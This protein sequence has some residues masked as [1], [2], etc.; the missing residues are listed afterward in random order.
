IS[1]D[2][3]VA[4]KLHVEELAKDKAGQEQEKYDLEKALELQKQLDERQEVV[5]GKKLMILIGLILLF[6]RY[7][8]LQNRPFSIVEVRKNMYQNHAFVL[9]DSEIEKEVMK[10]PGFD[11]Q[12]KFIKKNEKIEASGFVQKQPAGEEKEK[13]KDAESSKQVKEEIAQQ[14]DVVAEQVMKESSK[15]AGRR[16]KRKVAKGIED[17]DKMKKMQDDPEKHTLME[18]VEI[19]LI[20]K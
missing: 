15:K 4:Q 16:L 14:E 11:L 18:Y 3:E 17:K 13:K 5:F 20:E 1:H 6:K 8:A 2:E 12:Q 10:R 19:N 7:H 9:K